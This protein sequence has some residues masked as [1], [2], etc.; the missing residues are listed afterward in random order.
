MKL[1]IALF[2]VGLMV[3][4]VSCTRKVN[5]GDTSKNPMAAHFSIPDGCALEMG[6]GIDSQVGIISCGGNQFTFDYGRYSYKGP[7]NL[8]SNFMITFHN[9]HYSRFFME[10]GMDEKV[11]KALRNKVK[12]L[13]AR[14]IDDFNGELMFEC[15]TCNAV[16]ELEYENTRFYFPYSDSKSILQNEQDYYFDVFVQDGFFY[17][18][19][20]ASKET[21]LYAYHTNDPYRGNRL[22]VLCERCLPSEAIDVLKK[23]RMV[24]Q[25]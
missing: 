6:Q 7:E 20:S 10:L 9:Y 18:V 17:K 11:Y 15:S 13:S 22:S 25:E 16:A 14:V 1:K 4:Q 12:I 2:I 8:M 19:F 24:P 23:I 21:G 3:L 5:S